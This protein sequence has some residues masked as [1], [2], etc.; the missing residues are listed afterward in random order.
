LQSE[1]FLDLC[2]NYP[3]PKKKFLR[4]DTAEDYV[5]SRIIFRTEDGRELGPEDYLQEF[6]RFVKENP[7]HIEALEILLNCP[8]ALYF[9]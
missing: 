3:R 2:E 7:E 6:E 5:S 8:K 1:A 4:A 9:I